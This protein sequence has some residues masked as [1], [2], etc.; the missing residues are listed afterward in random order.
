MI[1]AA[2]VTPALIMGMELGKA[3][4]ISH[5]EIMLVSLSVGIWAPVVSD[6]YI[7]FICILHSYI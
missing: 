1:G 6:S 2:I 5:L 3:L 4:R 7:Y